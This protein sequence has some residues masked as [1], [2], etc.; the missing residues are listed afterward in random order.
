MERLLQHQILS[1]ELSHV[2]GVF[3]TLLHRTGMFEKQ[4]LPPRPGL[5]PHDPLLTLAA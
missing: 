3:C 1:I 2:Y 4:I 5:V